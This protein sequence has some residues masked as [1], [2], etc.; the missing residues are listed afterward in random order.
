MENI[1]YITVVFLLAGIVKGVTG[2]GLPTVALALLSLV[3]TPVEA[4]AL[5]IVPSLLTNVWQLLSGAPVYPLWQRLWPMMAGICVGTGLGTVAGTLMG[6]MM[7]GAVAA[8]AK[9]ASGALG[10]ALVAYAAMGLLSLRWR[11]RASEAMMSPAVGAVTG[12]ITVATGVF[13]IPAVPYLQA[14]E[15][16]KDDLVQA[17]G[18]AF[19]VSTV[20]LAVSLAA[21]G[22]WQPAAAG[23]SFVAQLP[24]VAGMLLGQRLRSLMA[25]ALFRKCFLF[26]LLLLGMHLALDAAWH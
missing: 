18:L 3:M 12:A 19:T 23:M 4:A 24:A 6:G 7:G 26:A 11:L 8:D 17:M 14:L 21:R 1:I 2:M 22:A 15:L 10:V 5:L 16:E 20:A 25:P 13:V 9:M